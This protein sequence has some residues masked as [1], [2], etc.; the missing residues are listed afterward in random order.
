MRRK[1]ATPEVE[2]AI[3]RQAAAQHGNLTRRQLLEAGLSRRAIDYRVRTGRLLRRHQGVY[4][5]GHHPPSPLS[6][7]MAAVLACGPVAVLSHLSAAALWQ[8]GPRWRT[9]IE[10]TARGNHHH[11]GIRVHRSPAVERTV[12]YGIPVTAPARTLLDLADLLDDAALARAVNQARLARQVTLEGLRALL[13]QSP[14]RGTSRLRALIAHDTGPTRSHFED[15]FLRFARRHQLPTPEVNQTIAGHEVDLF[16]C[17]QRLVVELDSREHHRHRF[18]EDRE[19]DA[20]LLNAGVAVLRITWSRLQRNPHAKRSGCEPSSPSARRLP[21]GP[22]RRRRSARDRRPRRRRR[23]S[24]SP[25]R[26][27]RRSR[28]ARGRRA[29]RA[30]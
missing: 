5:L 8:L 4:A 30:C 11:A 20:D 29:A 6:T 13:D 3:A 17:P 28:R 26:A 12:H 18:E 16:W 7:A 22:A 15:A 2:A 25:P 21:R 24:A 9:P 1:E 10:V 27:R 19:R 23:A 14:G